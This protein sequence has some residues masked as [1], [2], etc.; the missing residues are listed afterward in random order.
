M[1][2]I[3]QNFLIITVGH[4]SELWKSYIHTSLSYLDISKH[5]PDQLQQLASPAVKHQWSFSEIVSQLSSKAMSRSQGNIPSGPGT[6]PER[7]KTGSGIRL[8][9]FFC[10]WTDTHIANQQQ[11]RIMQE[12]CTK[13]SSFQYVL[14]LILCMLPISIIAGFVLK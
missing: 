2:W 5:S 11:F 9:S 1:L 10:I 8:L 3:F 4:V 7:W 14:Y 6:C 13:F 12:V